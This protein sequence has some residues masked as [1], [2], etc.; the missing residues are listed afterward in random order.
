MLQV[1]EEG[2]EPTA[3]ASGANQER[4]YAGCEMYVTDEIR[5]VEDRLQSP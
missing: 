1:C 3:V 4:E 5:E 2:Q